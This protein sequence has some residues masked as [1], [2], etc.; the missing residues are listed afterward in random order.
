MDYSKLKLTQLQRLIEDRNIICKNNKTEMIK[1][2]KMDDDGLYVKDTQYEKFKDGFIV[3][4][5]VRNKTDFSQI[6][7]LIEKKEAY[8]LNRYSNDR[9]YYFTKQKLI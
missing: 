9:V 1:Y 7:K 6:G 4:I 8:S 5:D 3:G 2:L